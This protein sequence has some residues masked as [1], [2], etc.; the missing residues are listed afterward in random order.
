METDYLI[1]DTMN[2]LKNLIVISNT[3]P[4]K[5]WSIAQRESVGEILHIPFPQFNPY[6]NDITIHIFE[7]YNSIRKYLNK[8]ENIFVDGDPI[9]VHT[10]LV[11]ISE[12]SEYNRYLN[13]VFPVHVK[14]DECIPLLNGK[15]GNMRFVQWRKILW[16]KLPYPIINIQVPF[17]K[18]R[19][20]V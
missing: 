4:E 3:D 7:F 11:K 8:Y 5:E 1:G 20:M 19:N 10:L 15:T 6:E 2:Q 18:K 9:V 13:F 12:N 14:T 16:K 17:N